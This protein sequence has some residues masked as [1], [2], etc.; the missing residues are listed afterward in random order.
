[1]RPLHWPLGSRRVSN[2]EPEE[3]PESAKSREHRR[4]MNLERCAAIRRTMDEQIGRP[5]VKLIVPEHGGPPSAILDPATIEF[6]PAKW[7]RQARSTSTGKYVRTRGK[8]T[9]SIKGDET[10]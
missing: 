6:D 8:Y 3:I 7:D 2:D 4:E 1:M 9:P 10:R 5:N